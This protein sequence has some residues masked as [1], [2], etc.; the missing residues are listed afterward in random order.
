MPYLCVNKLYLCQLLLDKP[1][2]GLEK[3]NNKQNQKQQKKTPNNK[4]KAKLIEN[5]RWKTKTAILP[6]KPLLGSNEHR[7]VGATAW[8]LLYNPK[9]LQPL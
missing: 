8:I 7:L 9:K 4:T 1:I 3:K 6:P 5:T 2:L